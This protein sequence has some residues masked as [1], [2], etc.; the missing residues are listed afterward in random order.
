VIVGDK[1]REAGGSGRK[2][3]VDASQRRHVG[4]LF[5]LPGPTPGSGGISCT[6]QSRSKVPHLHPWTTERSQSSSEPW[7]KASQCRWWSP[8]V[9]DASRDASAAAAAANSLHLPC[10]SGWQHDDPNHDAI[11]P[12]A[13]RWRPSCLSTSTTSAS[14]SCTKQ[15]HAGWSSPFHPRWA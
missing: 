6:P 2:R 10:A 8:T 14:R 4:D 3:G 12:A 9:P 7:S 13:R 1:G 15:C 11:S 5:P